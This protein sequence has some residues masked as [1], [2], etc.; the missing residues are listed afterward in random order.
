M[1]RDSYYG[2]CARHLKYTSKGYWMNPKRILEN[3]SLYTRLR[4][5]EGPELLVM[6]CSCSRCMRSK[7]GSSSTVDSKTLQHGCRMIQ[8]GVVVSLVWAWRTLMF[9][10]ASVLIMCVGYYLFL[11]VCHPRAAVVPYEPIS[12]VTLPPEVLETLDPETHQCCSRLAFAW[13]SRMNNMR[14][15]P[16][17]LRHK[18]LYPKG[19][20]FMI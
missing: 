10:L 5:F 4:K 2:Y 15:N 12:P 18:V 9:K 14:C 1:V 17:G 8:S 19:R 7:R 20:V 16:D 6:L 13:R 11:P 3:L